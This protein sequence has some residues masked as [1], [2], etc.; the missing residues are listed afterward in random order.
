MTPLELLE[1]VLAVLAGL[2]FAGAIVTAIE[3][4]LR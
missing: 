2:F 4:G 1:K 3:W